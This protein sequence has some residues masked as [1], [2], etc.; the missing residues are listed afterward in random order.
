VKKRSCRKCS[1]MPKGNNAAV[2]QAWHL[3]AYKQRLQAS[4]RRQGKTA[5]TAATIRTA[6]QCCCCCCCCPHQVAVEEGP[7]PALATSSSARAHRGASSSS[8]A[9]AKWRP[10]AV[11]QAAAATA[12]AGVKPPAVKCLLHE[13][14]EGGSSSAHQRSNPGR[15]SRAAAVQPRVSYYGYCRSLAALMRMQQLVLAYALHRTPTGL[16]GPQQEQS[17]P[18]HAWSII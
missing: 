10:Q 17:I 18:F 5:T 15:Q 7:Q 16:V 11:H 9:P 8:R 14:G 12:I 1:R 6:S 4:Q 2:Q 3:E 13:G